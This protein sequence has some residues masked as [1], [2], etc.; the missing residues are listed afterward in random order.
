MGSAAHV[1]DC[2]GDWQY[3]RD[4]GY[5][6]SGQEPVEANGSPEGRESLPIQ[7]STRGS[8]VTAISFH[9]FVVGQS[10]MSYFHVVDDGAKIGSM[11]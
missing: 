4:D 9:A 1:Y 6:V 5:L 10:L 3:I 8:G 11:G 7:F 2:P